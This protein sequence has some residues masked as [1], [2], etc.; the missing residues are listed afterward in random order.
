M[1]GVE[2]PLQGSIPCHSTM[3]RQKVT[4]RSVSYYQATCQ[5]TWLGPKRDKYGYAVQDAIDHTKDHIAESKRHA[6]KAKNRG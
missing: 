1:A 2:F 5:C 6:E 3:E 4:V